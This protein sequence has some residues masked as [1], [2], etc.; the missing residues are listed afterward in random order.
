MEEL[1]TGLCSI[2]AESGADPGLAL[3]LSLLVGV[4]LVSGVPLITVILA[5][6]D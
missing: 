1:C 2:L 4:L 5:H 6:L 3:F